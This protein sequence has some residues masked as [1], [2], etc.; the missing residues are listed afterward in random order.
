MHV[1][2][3]PGAAQEGARPQ[4]GVR[5]R[6]RVEVVKVGVK[7]GGL[8]GVCGHG[9]LPTSASALALPPFWGPHNCHIIEEESGMHFFFP[10]W[11]EISTFFFAGLGRRFLPDL[12]AYLIISL[13][14]VVVVISIRL[15]LLER[16]PELWL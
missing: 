16:G 11:L 6:E 9:R 14:G 15:P 13:E 7:V 4:L 12:H 2:P 3:G 1:A 10:N 5:A 8:G